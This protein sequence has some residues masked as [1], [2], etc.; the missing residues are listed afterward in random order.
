MMQFTTSRKPSPKTRRF[1]KTLATFLSVPYITRGKSNLDYDETWMVVVEDH[2]NPQGLVRRD[3][4]GEKTLRFTISAERN[5]SQTKR[6]KPVVTGDS[7][8]AKAIA[9][10][11][12]LD[13][14]PKSKAIRLINVKK[15]GITEFVDSGTNIV[16]LKI[17]EGTS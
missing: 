6:E 5:M 4:R 16:K 8:M 7:N 13:Y 10:F 1:A 17:H 12:D 2:G 15:G 14:D 9:E 3:R 11:L